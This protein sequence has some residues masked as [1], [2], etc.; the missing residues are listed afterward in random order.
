MNAFRPACDTRGRAFGP[1]CALTLL[2][3][4][5]AGCASG[6]SER[7][8]LEDEFQRAV[9][10]QGPTSVVASA[11]PRGT[12]TERLETIWPATPPVSYTHLRAHET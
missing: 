7:R 1:P 5:L 2:T 11:S 12:G 4:W 9:A 8:A 3:L 10:R 6:A